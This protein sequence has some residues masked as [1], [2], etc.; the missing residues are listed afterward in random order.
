M[1]FRNSDIWLFS[2]KN[3]LEYKLFFGSVACISFAVAKHKIVRKIFSR[4]AY[5]LKTKS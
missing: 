2:Q 1:Q 4:F 3:V 5:F